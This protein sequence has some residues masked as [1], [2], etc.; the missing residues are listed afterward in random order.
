[1]PD[2]ALPSVATHGRDAVFRA[3]KRLVSDRPDLSFE[4]AVVVARL[5]I[6]HQG[7]PRPI[8]GKHRICDVA[9]S[10]RLCKA[11]LT[12]L[13]ESWDGGMGAREQAVLVLRASERGVQLVQRALGEPQTHG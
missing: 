8:R 5:V 3:A 10:R 11:G 12:E 2:S 6:E 13:M 9:A 4:D 1:V 7:G